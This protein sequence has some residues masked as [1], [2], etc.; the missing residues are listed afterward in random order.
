MLAEL[1]TIR[2]NILTTSKRKKWSRFIC[3]IIII[4]YTIIII[5]M[6]PFPKNTADIENQQEQERQIMEMLKSKPELLKKYQE[7]L[8]KMQGKQKGRVVQQPMTSK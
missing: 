4:I 2:N 5:W 3:L 7:E 8:T 1:T 6:N